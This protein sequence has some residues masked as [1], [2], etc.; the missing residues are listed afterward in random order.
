MKDETAVTLMAIGCIT[1]LAAIYDGNLLYMAVG[2]IGG[3]LAP[4]P[5]QR[6]KRDEKPSE[7]LAQPQ[8]GG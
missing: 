3:I 1:L 6:V 8:R 4:S 7:V 2:L 5:L